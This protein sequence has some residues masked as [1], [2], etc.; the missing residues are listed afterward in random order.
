MINIPKWI[1]LSGQSLS[2]NIHACCISQVPIKYHN[3]KGFW[4]Q[5]LQSGYHFIP[6]FRTWTTLWH[7]VPPTHLKVD[8]ITSDFSFFTTTAVIDVLEKVFL[9]NT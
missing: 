9:R 1:T 2:G 6:S 8:S 7:Q 3:T 4:A 5:Y